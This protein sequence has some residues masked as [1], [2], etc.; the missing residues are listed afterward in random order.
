MHRIFLPIYRFLHSRQW[1]MYLLLVMSFVVFVAFGLQLRFEEDIVKLLPRS[2]T[3]NELAFSEID[4]KEKVF[5]QVVSSD[6]L[7]PAST[8][9]TGAGTAA[10][11]ASS[12]SRS[13]GRT[14]AR[15]GTSWANIKVAGERTRFPN[16]PER[17]V[18]SGWIA[19]RLWIGI[20]GRSTYSHR[21]KRIRPSRIT[22][23]VKSVR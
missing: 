20:A 18:P 14:P 7:Q 2:S 12:P 6:T 17:P 8:A 10:R 23:G 11:R 13:P 16:T 21:L 1:L 3:D 4:L 15:P 9:R 5:I 22:E 19:H